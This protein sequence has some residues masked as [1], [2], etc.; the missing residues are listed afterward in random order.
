MENLSA[1]KPRHTVLCPEHMLFVMQNG[2]WFVEAIRASGQVSRA[3]R[4]DTRPHLTNKN[5]IRNVLLSRSHPHRTK[6]TLASIEPRTAFKEIGS[7]SAVTLRIV[8]LRLSLVAAR[9]PIFF[10]NV[11]IRKLVFGKIADTAH[12]KTWPGIPLRDVSKFDV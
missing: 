11:H 10:G 7:R 6:R 8:R 9:Q 4:P 1:L 12:K 2:T 5:H 3:N